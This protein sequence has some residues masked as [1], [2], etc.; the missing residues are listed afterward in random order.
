[1]KQL[2]LVIGK[3]AFWLCWP[4]LFVYLR[5]GARTRVLLVVDDKV[6]VV[7]GWF[8]NGKW[9][10]PGGGLHRGEDPLQGALRELKEETGITLDPK[11]LKAKG[12]AR[13]KEAGLSFAYYQFEARLPKELPLQEQR[14][15]ITEATWMPMDQLS[16]A[17]APTSTL[18][19]VASWQRNS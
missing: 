19:M 4:A 18:A 7:Q 1:M 10:L 16:K 3:A 14:I 15:E 17:N 12:P 9:G 2:W 11:A 6:L 5:I 8:G 13:A